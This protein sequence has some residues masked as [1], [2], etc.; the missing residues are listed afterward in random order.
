MKVDMHMLFRH[1]KVNVF[2]ITWIRSYSQIL[3]S[4]IKNGSGT[5]YMQGKMNWA[6][7]NFILTIVGS[8]FDGTWV[9]GGTF[10]DHLNKNK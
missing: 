8:V 2:Q 6:I 3:L 5:H 9:G 1:N 4:A 10:L 7:T